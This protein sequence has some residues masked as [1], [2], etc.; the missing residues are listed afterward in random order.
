MGEPLEFEFQ[1]KLTKLR[2]E[3]SKKEVEVRGHM[4]SIEKIRVEALKK[5]EEMKYSAQH[6]IEKINHDITKTKNLDPQLKT[7]LDSEISAL[8]SEIERKYGELRNTTLGKV[9]SQ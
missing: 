1:K 2:E 5:T 6:E 4:A 9:G 3:L 7:R 8:R